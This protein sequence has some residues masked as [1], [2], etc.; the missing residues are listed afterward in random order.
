V[1]SGVTVN[2]RASGKNF[3]KGPPTYIFYL[4]GYFS[5]TSTHLLNFFPTEMLFTGHFRHFSYHC[6]YINVTR[7]A[8]PLRLT[9][10]R[11]HLVLIF[12]FKVHYF[13]VEALLSFAELS[14]V[15]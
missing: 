10:G 12:T 1:P 5:A 6:K 14:C 9:T 8:Q 13:I 4:K 2:E 7:D 15:S 3:M 11:I